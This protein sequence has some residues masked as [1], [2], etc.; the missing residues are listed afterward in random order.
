MNYLSIHSTPL[1]NAVQIMAGIVFFFVFGMEAMGQTGYVWSKTIQGPSWFEAGIDVDC[2]ASGAVFIAGEYRNNTIFG[3]VPE[4]S[5]G[6][7]DMYTCRMDPFGNFDWVHTEGNTATDRTFA[8]RVGDDR[9][10][11]SAGYGLVIFP[12]HRVGM[13]AWD[14]ITMRLRP[15]GS[16]HWGWA[17]NGGGAMDYSEALDIVADPKGNSYT[18]GLMKNDGWYGL[19]TIEGIGAE[20]A[21]ISKFDSTGNYLWGKAFGGSLDDQAYGVDVGPDGHI[22]VGGSFHGTADFGGLPLTASGNAD[23]F[24]TKIDSNGNVVFARQIQGPSFAEVIR[25]KVSADGDCYFAG[26]FSGTITVGT[27]TLVCNDTTDIFYGKMDAAGNFLWAKRAGGFD[28]SKVQDIEIDS[29]ENVYLGGYF[30]GGFSWQGDSATSQMWDDMYFGKADSNGVLDFVEFSGDLASRDVFGIAVDPAQNILL[31]GIFSDTLTFGG[32]THSSTLGTTDIFVAKY[33]S[34]VQE[35]AIVSLTGT[36]FCSAD[37]FVVSFHAW[38][39]FDSTNVFYLELSDANGSFANPDVVGSLAG[40]YGGSITGTVPNGIVQGSQYRVR[41]RATAPALVS[42][43]NGQD[44]ALYPSTAVPVDI[45]GD[46]VLCNGQ[47]VTLSIDPWLSHQIWSTGDTSAAI[48]VSVPGVVWVEATDTNGC[49]NRDEVLVT[50]CVGLQEAQTGPRIQVFPNPSAGLF[51]I[52]VE[53]LLPGNY[54]LAIFDSQGRQVLVRQQ[55][56]RGGISLIPVDLA[57]AAAGIYFAK[58]TGSDSQC[59]LRFELQ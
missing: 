33:A 39:N 11:Y 32:T 5:W 30:F 4:V 17:M 20:D 41:I 27:Q 2:D 42:P 38:G 52:K 35:M 21:F 29:E 13:H 14:A 48:T 51:Q 12:A 31:T 16:L 8:V 59:G 34:R 23:G 46:T 28:Q 57:G 45:S 58:L 53:G 55:L 19:D 1:R 7:T 44:F 3:G 18:V 6:L 40:S 9:H 47:P 54:Q 24:I 22:W 10:I 50:L 26:N 36:P 15:D 43:D 37:Q 49:S 56:V 25:L